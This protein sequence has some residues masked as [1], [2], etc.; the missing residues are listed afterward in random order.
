MS[1]RVLDTVLCAIAL[2]AA[3]PLLALA[4]LGIKLTS[5]GPVLYR[6]SRVGRGG[7]IF[8]MY[9]LRTMHVERPTAAVAESAITARDDPR[10]FPF[11]ALLRWSKIDE[12]PQLFNVLR[13]DMAIV[14]PRPEDPRYVTAHYAPIHFETL[15]VRPGLTSP[16]SVWYYACAEEQ[17]EN[18]D[19][20]RQYVERVLPLKLALDLVYLRRATMWSDVAVIAR[21]VGVLLGRFVGRRAFADPPEMSEARR[22]VVRGVAVAL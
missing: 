19:A 18:G 22:F 21:T 1:S 4:A 16:G 10:V 11:G 15:D 13:G 6:A 14:G 12:L 20:E 3:T 5:P 8:S 2:V 7:R 9:K 17:L